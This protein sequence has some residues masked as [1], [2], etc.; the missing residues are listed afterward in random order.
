MYIYIAIALTCA[1]ITVSEYYRLDLIVYNHM[2]NLARF[3]GE[4]SFLFPIVH[5]YYLLDSPYGHV[6]KYYL[7][8]C[9]P[10]SGKVWQ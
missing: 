10:Y 2:L 4:P 1:A 9:I 6:Q 3:Y 7:D 8:S 5:V